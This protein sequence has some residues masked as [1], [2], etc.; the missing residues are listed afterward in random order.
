MIDRIYTSFSLKEKYFGPQ[1]PYM[2]STSGGSKQIWLAGGAGS[3][4]EFRAYGTESPILSPDNTSFAYIAEQTP[5]AR[6]CVCA[7]DGSYNSTIMT[8][9]ISGG[10]LRSPYWLNNNQIVY[11]NVNEYGHF[12]G[13]HTINVIN[14]DGSGNTVLWTNDTNYGIPLYLSCSPSG[15]YIQFSI[16]REVPEYTRPNELWVMNANGSNPHLIY[17]APLVGTQQFEGYTNWG[18]QHGA[19]VVGFSEIT[20]WAP[21]TQRWRTMNW[22]GSG[23]TT[24]LANDTGWA[25]I[26]ESIFS[27]LTNDSAM[28][29]LRATGGTPPYQLYTVAANGSG[30]TAIS[31]ARYT[32]DQAGFGYYKSTVC[33]I[34]GRIYWVEGL[35]YNHLSSI[36]EDGSDYRVE[37]VF[38]NDG[39][40]WHGFLY[41]GQ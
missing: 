8:Q 22:D 36:A 27:W 7:V 23:L 18:W 24:I 33:V 16:R 35:Y 29:G 32:H 3:H 41:Y 5:P 38:A 13:P 25:D 34:R 2:V 9:S 15:N 12:L 30:A 40:V 31:P 26:G 28:V 1:V 37:H 20:S 4:P 14:K 39:L 6:L 11:I 19:D 10:S 21:T 17:T